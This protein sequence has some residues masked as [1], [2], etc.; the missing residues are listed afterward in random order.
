[1]NRK[2]KILQLK[3]EYLKLELEEINESMNEY[4]S[5]FDSFF[6]KYYVS[7]KKK[8]IKFE[9][10]NIHFENAKRERAEKD[11]EQKERRALLKNAPTKV[12]TLYKKLATKTH[13]DKTGGDESVFQSV[14]DAY[15]SQDLAEML[16]L[17]GK[18]GV[19]YEMDSNDAILLERNLNKIEREINQV[20]GTIGWLW[21]TGD[22]KQRQFCVNR[23][24]DET[25]Q[26]IANEDLPE[27]LKKE[28]TKLIGKRGDDK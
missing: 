5:D 4:T 25:G 17:A 24:Q 13:P 6:S 22:L 1:M 18:F 15:E 11:K 10:P 8:T 27:D 21:G 7:S 2:L 12:K 26:T 14:K 28:E 23:V 3:H 20:K 16:D 19:K 9:N